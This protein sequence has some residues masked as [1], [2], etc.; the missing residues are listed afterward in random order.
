MFIA[1]FFINSHIAFVHSNKVSCSYFC[2][3]TQCKFVFPRFSFAVLISQL[4]N[5]SKKSIIA[6]STLSSLNIGSTQTFTSHFLIYLI[7]HPSITIQ[8]LFLSI[9]K[10]FYWFGKNDEL[11]T[12]RHNFTCLQVPMVIIIVYK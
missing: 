6:C 10:N 11:Q 1:V 3:T 8:I 7:D 12:L 4:I 2:L 5:F 9:T